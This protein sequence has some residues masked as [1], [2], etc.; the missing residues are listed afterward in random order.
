M[1]KWHY[2]W[3]GY[4][5]WMVREYATQ[6]LEDL[7]GVEA[8]NCESVLDAVTATE[9]M[10]NGGNRLKLIKMIHWNR[11]HTLEGAAVAIPCARSTAAKWQRE[12]FEEVA[13]NRGLMD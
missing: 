2:P 9:R 4:V 12:F 10:T 1:S 13:Q 7:T 3:W 11:T 8:V 5:R 6:C